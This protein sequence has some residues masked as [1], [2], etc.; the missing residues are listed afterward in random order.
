MQIFCTNSLST[1]SPEV[2]NTTQ[3]L[4]RID[5]VEIDDRINRHGHRV[6]GENLET[7]ELTHNQTPLAPLALSISVFYR[8]IHSPWKNSLLE[9]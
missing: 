4:L 9:W 5:Y 3:G 8:K 7:K 2:I 6:T 1:E